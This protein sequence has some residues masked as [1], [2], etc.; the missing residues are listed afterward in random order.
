MPK[1]V[2]CIYTGAAEIT[3][4]FRKIT[5]GSPTQIV[6]CGPFRQVGYIIKFSVVAM[7]WSDEHRGF[8][9]AAFLKNFHLSGTVNKQNFRYWAAENPRELMHDLFTAQK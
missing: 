6:G 5:V 2:M 3:P 9:V 8:V 1:H 7:P 4:T